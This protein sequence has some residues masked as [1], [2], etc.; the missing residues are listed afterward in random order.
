MPRKA[1]KKK[2]EPER[3]YSHRLLIDKLGLK[4]GQKV[5]V[6]GVEDTAF[7]KDLSARVPEFSSEISMGHADL[8]FFQ[9]EN[10]KELAR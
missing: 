1:A 7:L 9:A 5:V 4:P 8:I 3:D 6:L 2:R 10:M